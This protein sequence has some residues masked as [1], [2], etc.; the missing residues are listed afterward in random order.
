MGL[1]LNNIQHNFRALLGCLTDLFVSLIY[2]ELTSLKLPRSQLCIHIG[3]MPFLL[4]N[5]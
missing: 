5:Q 1:G 2:T 3:R 4:P